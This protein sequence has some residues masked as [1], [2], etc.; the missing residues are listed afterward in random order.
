MTT[1]LPIRTRARSFER[2]SADARLYNNGFFSL[3]LEV[4]LRAAGI[5][6]ASYGEQGARKAKVAG[7]N[8]VNVGPARQLAGGE[9][10]AR[11]ADAVITE[12]R[13]PN[14]QRNL[15][16]A[17]AFGGKGEGHCSVS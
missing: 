9:R 1:A 4:S 5:A 8:G 16:A 10:G 17:Q 14:L 12:L 13:P 7:R 11:C 3:S 15:D 2:L 6:V